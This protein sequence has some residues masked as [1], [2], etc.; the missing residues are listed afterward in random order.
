MV[1]IKNI[2]YE[3]NRVEAAKLRLFD[4]FK[5]KY[6]EKEIE[7][8]HDKLNNL[9]RTPTKKHLQKLVDYY[10]DGDGNVTLDH[11]EQ[12]YRKFINN[13]RLRNLDIY[14]YNTF[15]KFEELVD[16]HEKKHGPTMFKD[17]ELKP[18]YEDDKIAVWLGDS[19][20]KCIQLGTKSAGDAAFCIS[21]PLMGGGNMYVKY[22]FSDSITFYFVRFKNKPIEDPNHYIVIHVKNSK[23]VA[24]TTSTNTGDKAV[25]GDQLSQLFPE[26]STL[27][28]SGYFKSVELSKE[29]KA[30]KLIQSLSDK[31]K[32]SQNSEES[33]KSFIEEFNSLEDYD[34]AIYIASGGKIFDENWDKLT[35]TLKNDYISLATRLSNK[36]IKDISL[37]PGLHKRHKD[38]LKRTLNNFKKSSYSSHD[39]QVIITPVILRSFGADEITEYL[40]N[41]AGY[42]YAYIF[43]ASLKKIGEKFTENRYDLQNA[44]IVDEE[45]L[46]DSD[47]KER[48]K[49]CSELLKKIKSLMASNPSLS[50]DKNFM[51]EVKKL[52]DICKS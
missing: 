42:Q 41:E 45:L 6:S 49:Y 35:R 33:K 12:Y 24:Y 21:R 32:L 19:M 4:A 28:N 40:K 44:I 8:I 14:K 34:K 27:I 5:N 46:E 1:K 2:L 50:S 47:D 29:D 31:Y 17:T 10:I 18:D 36:I 22:R 26:L 52:S 7:I 20:N 39:V 3:V 11:I 48:R 23:I 9:D 38:V 13:T 25:N 16:S 15:T 30:Y 43:K 51:D 37:D